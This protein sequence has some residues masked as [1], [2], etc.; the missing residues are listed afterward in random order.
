MAASTPSHP[1]LTTNPPKAL[2]FD[3]FGTVVDWRT[4]VTSTLIARAFAKTSSST[5]ASLSPPTLQRLSE[6]TAR[7]WADFAQEWR[8]SYKAFV[9][10]YNPATD[11]WRDIDTH[12]RLSLIALLGKWGLDGLYSDDEIEELSKIWHH[13]DPWA[14]SAA[15]LKRLNARFITSTLS[16]GTRSL[17]QDLQEHGGLGFQVIQC[18]EDFRAY[19]PHPR[20]YLGACEKMGLEPREV[21]MVA[22]H[23]NDL[24]AARGMGMR[25]IYVERRREEDWEVGGEEYRDARTWVD[26]W[27]SQ[28]EEGF[29]E[30]ARRF[31]L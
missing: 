9:K 29:V 14:D 27:V 31:G 25:T 4:T 2:T 1:S 11:A 18:S 7:S 6:L 16:N 8:N 24:K 3:V 17:L 22:A 26:M 20:T 13:L 21:A 5:S 19:K 12:H 28:E 15:G 23:L 10:S 30:V